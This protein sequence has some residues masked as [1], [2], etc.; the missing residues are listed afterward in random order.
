MN[1]PNCQ[2]SVL[3][4]HDSCPNCGYDLSVYWSIHT[5]KDNIW[6]IKNEKNISAMKT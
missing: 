5:L 3:D 4:E 1:C 2:Q 6:G